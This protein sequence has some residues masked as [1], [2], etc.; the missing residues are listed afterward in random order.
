MDYSIMKELLTLDMEFPYFGLIGSKN[1]LSNNFKKAVDE[2]IK[3]EKLE[4]LYAPVGL[5][6]GGESPTDIA[7]S[8][9]SEILMIKNQKSGKHLRDITELNF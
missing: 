9:L 8:I 7:I 5:D 1:K 4:K 6:T 3:R 2:G